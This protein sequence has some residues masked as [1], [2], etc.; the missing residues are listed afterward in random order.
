M[1]LTA[2]APNR[3]RT[4]ALCFVWSGG[5][6]SSLRSLAEGIA[7]ALPEVELLGVELPG[8]GARMKEPFFASFAEAIEGIVTALTELELEQQLLSACPLLLMGY[9]L[10]SFVAHQVAVMLEQ[11]LLEPCWPCCFVMMAVTNPPAYLST[12]R[13]YTHLSDAQI[14]EMLKSGAGQAFAELGPD[15]LAAVLAFFVPAMR[16]DLQLEESYTLEGW[17]QLRC[18]IVAIGGDEDS[19]CSSEALPGWREG[20][21]GNFTKYIVH[22]GHFFVHHRLTEVVK[23]I[24]DAVL[25]HSDI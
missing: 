22:G 18:S 13:Q 10:G 8:K 5:S 2:K 15:E 21:A 24:V 12:R 16:A 17:G 9:S 20:T 6:A 25:C 7:V 14:G 3:P 19:K 4:R 1:P 23:I 11:R